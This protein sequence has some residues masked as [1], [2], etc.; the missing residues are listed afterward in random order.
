MSADFPRSLDGAPMLLPMEMTAVRGAL[1]KWF[2]SLGIKP[3]VMGEFD[4]SALIK[5]FG[6]E[7][8]GVFVALRVIEAETLRQYLK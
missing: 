5:V 2:H 6:Q 7:G 1:D 4:D 3:A 8:H